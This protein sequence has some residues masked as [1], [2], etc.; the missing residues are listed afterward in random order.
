MISIRHPYDDNKEV[1]IAY[2]ENHLIVAQNFNFRFIAIT[3][4]EVNT[5]ISQFQNPDEGNQPLL[6]KEFSG[7]IHNERIF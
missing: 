2:F 5:T 4:E 3:H 7:I 1:D 6:E